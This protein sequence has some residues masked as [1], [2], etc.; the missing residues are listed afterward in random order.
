MITFSSWARD[1]FPEGRLVCFGTD[2]SSPKFRTA[3][4]TRMFHEY[5]QSVRF[6]VLANAPAVLA[7]GLAPVITMDFAGWF[8]ARKIIS[9]RIPEEII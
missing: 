5:F 6:Y 3:D 2:K 8:Y 4:A 1:R 9:R 7:E